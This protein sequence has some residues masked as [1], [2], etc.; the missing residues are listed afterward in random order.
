MRIVEDTEISS[1]HKKR[2]VLQ[3]LQG[4]AEDSIDLHRDQSVD[5]ILEI[6]DKLY[7]SVADG[8]DLLADFYHQFQEKGQTSS[9]YL[10]SL[11][12][13]L[14][15]V[16]KCETVSRS[17][18]SK[19]L[20]G[21]F[22]RGIDDEELLSKLRLEEKMDSPPNY[23]DLLTVVRR[24]ESRRTERK[25]RHSKQ[26]KSQVATV[27]TQ[28]VR[29][30]QQVSKEVVQ[31]QQRIVELEKQVNT[32]NKGDH[33]RVRRGFCYRCGLDGHFAMECHGIQ[34]TNL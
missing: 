22:I 29:E 7:G 27:E 18:M 28:V 30:K 6:L 1:A 8:S 34:S 21:Q 17:E 4:K 13:L 32:S 20:L 2:I 10:S 5:Q 15:E 14:S 33:S 31:L 12:V 19:I 9:E 25:L 23:P 26:V 3:S 16:V 24:E 11:F